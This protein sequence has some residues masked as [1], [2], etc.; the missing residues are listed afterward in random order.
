VKAK[1]HSAITASLNEADLKR[2][3]TEQGFEVVAN[4]PEEFTKFQAQELARWRKVI[5]VGHI[6]ID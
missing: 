6:E 5:E 4:S 1:L 3:L 2:R